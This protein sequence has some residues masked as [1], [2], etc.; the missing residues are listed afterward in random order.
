RRLAG[1]PD[2]HE[3]GSEPPER[4]SCAAGPPSDPRGGPQARRKGLDLDEQ[5]VAL[6]AA[7]ADRRE[8]EP[9]AVPAQLVHQRPDDPAAAGADRVTEGDGAAVDVRPLLVGSEHPRRVQRDRRER[10]VDRPAR[11][12]VRARYAKSSATYACARIVASG[13]SPR[14]FANSSEQTITHD[15]PSFTPGALPA[16]VVPSGSKTGL[17]FAKDSSEV[18]RRTLSSAVTSP[19]GTISSANTPES[20]AAAARWCDR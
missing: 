8:P 5:R 15:A 4:R 12:G 17:S 19:T 2:P 14:R 6:A 16:V 18:S 9:A 20:C 11:A 13:S 1:R 10:L 7:G 3:G